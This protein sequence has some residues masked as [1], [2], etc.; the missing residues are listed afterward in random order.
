MYNLANRLLESF[1][2]Y[3]GNVKNFQM[4]FYGVLNVLALIA[5]KKI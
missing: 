4:L 5:L 3:Y 2:Q 1:L